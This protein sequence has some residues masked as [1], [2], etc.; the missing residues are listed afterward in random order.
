MFVWIIL[1]VAEKGGLVARPRRNEDAEAGK[2][3]GIF[4][5]PDDQV[6]MRRLCSEF[7][8]NGA[9]G[10]FRALMLAE[11]KRRGWNPPEAPPTPQKPPGEH[12]V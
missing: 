11:A 12:A 2:R 3:V 4:L 1:R 10:L 8:Q 7:Y 9:T 5:S 6:L